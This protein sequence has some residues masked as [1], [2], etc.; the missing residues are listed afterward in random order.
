MKYDIRLYDNHNY[1]VGLET[2]IPKGWIS[3]VANSLMKKKQAQEAQKLEEFSVDEQL[4]PK[5]VKKLT[6]QIDDVQKQVRQDL[7]NFKIHT[8]NVNDFKYRQ[9]GEVYVVSIL[10]DGYYEV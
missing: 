10:L 1:K 5:I 8:V 7:P 9:Q 2:T 6:A 4:H 3:D